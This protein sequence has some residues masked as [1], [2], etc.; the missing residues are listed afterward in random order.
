VARVLRAGEGFE[1][2][3]CLLSGLKTNILFGWTIKMFSL[4]SM[5]SILSL[6]GY[7]WVCVVVYNM[8]EKKL[9]VMTP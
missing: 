8:Y 3:A 7:R 4:F 2:L 9:K 1:L 5:F 6:H